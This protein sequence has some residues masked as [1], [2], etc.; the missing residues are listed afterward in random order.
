MT[1]EPLRL[2]KSPY[3][4]LAVNTSLQKTERVE[5]CFLRECVRP[6]AKREMSRVDQQM[7]FRGL[8]WLG[9]WFPDA[10]IGGPV[11]PRSCLAIRVMT[12][13]PGRRPGTTT[14]KGL[15]GRLKRTA[16][17]KIGLAQCLRRLGVLQVSSGQCNCQGPRRPSKP[18]S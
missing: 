2:T 18:V 12:L 14:V 4:A 6:A 11:S 5:W 13:R 9:P 15:S 10:L 16:N 3:P 8:R 1:N 17:R 7:P